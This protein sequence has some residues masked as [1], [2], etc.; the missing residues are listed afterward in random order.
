MRLRLLAFALALLIPAQGW[1]AMAHVR[2]NCVTGNLF[3][4][5]TTY[6]YTYPAAYGNGNLLVITSVQET[7]SVSSVAGATLTYTINGANTSNA[8]AGFNVSQWKAIGN[9]SGDTTVTV[10]ISGAYNNTFSLVCF[11]EFSGANSDQ[12]SSV[13]N[14]SSND[15]LTAHNSGTVTPPSADNVVVATTY[16]SGGVWTPDAGF[17]AVTTGAS[18]GEFAY[19]VQAAATVQE[20][21]GTTDVGRYSAMRIGAFAGTAGGGGGGGPTGGSL[22]N[23]FNRRLQVNP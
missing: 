15:A 7:R 14:G 20:Y 12:S 13:A 17:T 3:A 6:A 21:N 1:A 9:G 19:L 4:G 5:G 16:I 11:A 8:T 10:T 18:W 22:L 23:M 2:S